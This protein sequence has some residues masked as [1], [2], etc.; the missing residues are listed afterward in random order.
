LSQEKI[1]EKV[2]SLIEER[3]GCPRSVDPCF[4]WDNQIS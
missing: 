3:D 4:L 1:E 2:Y